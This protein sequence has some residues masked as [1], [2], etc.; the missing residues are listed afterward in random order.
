MPQTYTGGCGIS[1]AR[2]GGLTMT[3]T[4]PFETRQ[5]SSRC[6]G[7]TIQREAWYSSSVSGSRIFARAFM[8]AHARSA[9]AIAPNWSWLVP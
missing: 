7:S 5:Q 6:N 1:F 4:A 2:S 3:A 8:V 9:T